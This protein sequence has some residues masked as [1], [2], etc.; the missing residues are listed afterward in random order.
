MIKS[1]WQGIIPTYSSK[2]TSSFLTDT[3]NYQSST[4]FATEVIQFHFFF[5]YNPRKNKYL[6]RPKSNYVTVFSNYEMKK[7]NLLAFVLLILR[8]TYHVASS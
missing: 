8:L 7:K 6:G 1:Q 4:N 5:P 2:R 3:K